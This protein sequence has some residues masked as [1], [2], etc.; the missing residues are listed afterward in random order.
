MDRDDEL[1]EDSI[2]HGSDE[3]LSADNLRLPENASNLARLHAI[4]AW[5]TRRQK[6]TDIEIG[7]AALALQQVQQGRL[8]RLELQQQAERLQR[9][10]QEFLDAQ[11][12][13]QAYEEA[14]FLL[15]ESI[16]HTTSG[17][18]VLVEYYL[19]LEE[20]VEAE[21]QE[22]EIAG[23]PR[24]QALADVQHRVERVGAPGEE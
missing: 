13:L 2:E 4:R 1:S 16:A 11:Q 15:E 24:H 21:V 3:L 10:Q 12:R 22:R 9:L 19:A 5:L 17:Q 6:E 18:R 20:L 23:S 8:R 14:Q 7:E